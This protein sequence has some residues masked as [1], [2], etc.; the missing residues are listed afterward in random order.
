M[1]KNSNYSVGIFLFAALFMAA[2]G[3]TEGNNDDPDRNII[4]EPVETDGSRVALVIGNADYDAVNTLK[5]PTNDAEDM[6]ST[7]RELGFE[8]IEATNVS[9]KDFDRAIDEFGKRLKKGGVGLFFY[10]GHGI[11]VD[12]INYLVPT[13]AN[14]QSEGDTQYE[15]LPA[16]RVLAKMEDAGTTLSMVVLDACRDNPFK[17]SWTRS[18]DARGLA[19]VS[20]SPEGS[21]IA[22]ATSLG[23]VASDGEGRNGLFTNYLL[24]YIKQPNLTI[25][26]VL[27]KTGAAVSQAS[28]GQQSPWQLSSFYGDFYFAGKT[29][30][31]EPPE[32]QPTDD[33]IE[34]V[35]IQSGTFQM[36]SNDGESDEKPI[37]SVTV[38]SFYMGKY[39]VTQK[40]WREVMG[41]DPPEL[42]FKGCDQCPVENVSWNDIQEFIKKLNT[43]TGKN[44]RL[45]TEAEWEYAARG[46]QSY[47]YAGSD[48]IDNVAW[49]DGNSGSKT[50][51]VGQ[52]S[53]NG[54]GLYDMS[55]NVWEWCNDW[56]GDYSSGAVTNPKG[57][58]T[59][60]RRV[61]RGGSWFTDASYCRVANR[62]SDSPDYRNDTLGFR[63]V[64]Q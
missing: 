27:K 62:F 10:A 30:D 56:Y 52:K 42:Y 57:P 18:T 34:M 9:L 4:V 25:D 51:P 1:K 13:D 11:Q 29:N 49:Y 26:E 20:K 36:G 39:E 23:N 33:G 44:Y 43:K 48:N 3:G 19:V 22:Y 63:L 60:S 8:V 32:P 38:S 47:Q 37:H 17:R 31:P 5:N 21:I 50:H 15:C 46:G 45:P 7:L 14:L 28:N 61:L 2:C 35:S 41:Q 54:Y 53:P 59:V 16:D 64:S 58:S 12:G 55:G 24:Q 6:A 40:Q